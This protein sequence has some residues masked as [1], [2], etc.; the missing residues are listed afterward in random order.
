MSE[1][2]FFDI[3][4]GLK[5]REE[6]ARDACFKVVRRET[7]M[8]EHEGLG[9]E[10]RREMVHRHMS[11]EIT[12]L[13]IAAQC[14]VD[15]PETPWGLRMELARQCWDETRHIQ[16]LHRRLVEM[17]GYK[18]EFPISAFEWSITC[19]IDNLPGRLA[20][21]NRTFEAGAM[22]VVAGLIANIREA[23]DTTTADV[24][25]G[26][27]A[28]EVQH[29]RFANRWIKKMAS[30]DRRVLM[31]VAQAIRFLSEANMRLQAQQG[32]SSLGGKVYESPE[33]RIPAVNIADRKLAEFTDEEVNEILKQAGFRSIIPQ[34]AETVV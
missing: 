18:G 4:G 2:G 20:T 8:H 31:K 34:S 11:N 1:Y 7:D 14:L 29:V 19:A 32:Q 25:D 27:L 22:D 16:A 12:S 15:F 23:G 30:E 17:G 10:A 3:G 26:I 6:P 13:D 33:R 21:Q 9:D 24:L 28:D 5:M